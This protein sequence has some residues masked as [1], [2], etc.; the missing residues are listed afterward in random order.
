MNLDLDTWGPLTLLAVIAGTLLM[1]GG[2]V[3]V[4]T[5]SYS[6]GMFLNDLK[7]V[8]AALGL[9]AAVGRGVRLQPHVP[10]RRVRTSRRRRAD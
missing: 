9:G 1:L 2:V 6:F 5:T 7:P 10:A 3:E 4:C 8:A